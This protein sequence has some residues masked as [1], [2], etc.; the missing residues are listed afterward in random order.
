V[1]RKIGFRLGA[2]WLFDAT[3]ELALVF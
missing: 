2:L 1:A 3:F